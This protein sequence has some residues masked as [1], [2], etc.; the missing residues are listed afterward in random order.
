MIGE[1][2]MLQRF[3]VEFVLLGIFW[4]WIWERI[5]FFNVH[6]QIIVLMW[7]FGPSLRSAERLTFL[8]CRKSFFFCQGEQLIKSNK[9]LKLLSEIYWNINVLIKFHK[10]T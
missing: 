9:T 5:K 4:D 3:F 1:I 10:G 2:L 6:S 7:I 8:G